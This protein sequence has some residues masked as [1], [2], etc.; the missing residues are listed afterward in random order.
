MLPIP[1]DSELVDAA[2]ATYS[3]A[4][5]PLISDLGSAIQVYWTTRDDGLHNIAIEGTHDP[6]GWALDFFALRTI[7]H[8]GMIHPALGF[9]HA[10]FYLAA[11]AVVD[12]IQAKLDG[13]AYAICGHSLG[14]AMAL[15]LGAMLAVAGFPPVKIGAF[16]PPR[17]GG[18]MFANWIKT[19]PHC[20]YRY[21]HD[22]VPLVPMAL[23]PFFP[24]QQV[25]LIEIDAP[26]QRDIFLDHHI[27]NY[28][29]GVHAAATT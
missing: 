18:E 6:L 16:A 2:G 29:E 12:R 3:P 19:I 21:G 7:D 24:Y 26:F 8:G 20:A 11:N 14:A 9:I 10:G 4:A 5:I 23:Q 27:T 22:P 25:S 1:T 17:V 13:E 15:L 28:V